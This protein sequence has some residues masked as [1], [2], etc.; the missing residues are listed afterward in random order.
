MATGTITTTYSDREFHF[1]LQTLIFDG[2][3]EVIRN[4]FDQKLQKRPLNVVL[5]NEQKRIKSL[6][7]QKT[8]TRGQYDLLLPSRGGQYPTSADLDITLLICLLTNLPY[9]G[10]NLHYPWY[11]PPQQTDTSF[12]ADL[13]RLRNYRNE[14]SVTIKRQIKCKIMSIYIN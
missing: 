11:L 9:F 7:K 2:G 10:L 8:I 6:C 5:A 14:V 4:I 12:E 1:R 13:L 3:T